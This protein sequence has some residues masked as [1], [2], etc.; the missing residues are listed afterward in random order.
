MSQQDLAES[1]GFEDKSTI[2]RLE[3]GEIDLK[4]SKAARLSKVLQVEIQDLI[5]GGYKGV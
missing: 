1:I 5:K 3:S 4:T 2:C